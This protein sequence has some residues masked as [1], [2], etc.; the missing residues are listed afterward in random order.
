MNV[1]LRIHIY[2]KFVHTTAN[3]NLPKTLIISGSHYATHAYK[4][5]IIASKIF[6]YIIWILWLPKAHVEA[7]ISGSIALGGVISSSTKFLGEIP[8]KEFGKK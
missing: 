1:K 4:G 8:N 5:A 6:F 3:I 2:F 7:P